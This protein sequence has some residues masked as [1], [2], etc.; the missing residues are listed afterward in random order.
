MDLATLEKYLKAFAELKRNK[1]SGHGLAPHKPILLLSILDEIKEGRIQDNFIELTPELVATF[2]TY[3]K[4][5]VTDGYW[6]PK[7]EYPF[8]HLYQEGFWD[9]VQYGHIVAPEPMTYSLKQLRESFDGGRFAL[10]LWQLLQDGKTLDALH[11]HLLTVYFHAD[12]VQRESTGD[13]LNAAAQKLMDEAQSK[14][15]VRKVKEGTD[16]GYF[17]RHALFPRVVKRLYNHTCA[18]CGISARLGN[19]TTL[20]DAAHILEFSIF[21]YDDPRNGIALCKNHHWGFDSGAFAITED[22][23]II[24]SPVLAVSG[25]Y[26]T[27]N[28]LVALPENPLYHP[29]PNAL[30]WH[31]LNRYKAK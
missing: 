9:F 30:R 29:A 2:Q 12:T 10:D 22:Y 8:R 14:F 31:R 5:L 28:A 16:N 26:L 24:V 11:R 7:I 21:H 3:W 20:V 23:K 1:T 13:F 19:R 18:V 15:K 6:Q 17:I 27:S 4:A 25:L